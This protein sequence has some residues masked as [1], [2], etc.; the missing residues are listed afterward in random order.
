MASLDGDEKTSIYTESQLENLKM[1]GGMYNILE[2]AKGTDK[3]M[4]FGDV[5]EMISKML[6]I[7]DL[8]KET[9]VIRSSHDIIKRLIEMNAEIKYNKDTYYPDTV[10][11]YY[12]SPI[13]ADLL[14][15]GFDSF[16]CQHSET[17]DFL[18][19][20]KHYEFLTL[21]ICV[22]H[23]KKV[24]I[25]K[26]HS[27]ESLC[28]RYWYGS[29]TMY[30][31]NT[32]LKQKFESI[33]EMPVQVW[34]SDE[35][36]EDI[37][38]LEL[39]KQHRHPHPG[40]YFNNR[41][42]DSYLMLD[43]DFH[44][45]PHL[46]QHFKHIIHTKSKKTLFRFIISRDN[47][48]AAEIFS[49]VVGGKPFEDINMYRA[50]GDENIPY[51]KINIA[52]SLSREFLMT[53]YECLV[54]HQQKYVSSELIDHI[55]IPTEA[56]DIKTTLS[57]FEINS[58]IIRLEMEPEMSELKFCRCNYRPNLESR[59]EYYN[60]ICDTVYNERSPTFY[61]H[62][63]MKPLVD[64][65]HFVRNETMMVYFVN[66][67]KN[68]I[69]QKLPGYEKCMRLME[70]PTIICF[71][72]NNKIDIPFKITKD[73][74]VSIIKI[75]ARVRVKALRTLYKMGFNG[76]L[77]CLKLD[78]PLSSDANRMLVDCVLKINKPK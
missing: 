50:D 27:E 69:E 55:G 64:F 22:N 67:C 1:F 31:T 61:T 40:D 78:T 25:K 45:Y 14:K 2:S 23:A 8:L 30:K 56:I 5:N 15:I 72:L 62:N 63:K 47:L 71:Y 19:K 10:I 41:N 26:L 3:S 36:Y 12:A 48:S 29:I 77:H 65:R 33:K 70:H 7:I 42:T 60:F 20:Y 17:V 75:K 6:E 54:L 32:P 68:A 34:I 11:N 38:G 37:N 24:I 39:H 58:L 43:V 46:I 9:P 4:N 57:K 59:L 16:W 51:L 13:I 66:D 35:I 52:K 44:Q 21:E 76:I 28:G 53:Y 74:I 18:Y 49:E 73:H